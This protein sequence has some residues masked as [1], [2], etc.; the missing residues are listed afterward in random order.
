MNYLKHCLWLFAV[1][2]IVITDAS[3]GPACDPKEIRY[4]TLTTETKDGYRFDMFSPAISG[5]MPKDTSNIPFYG[6]ACSK[7]S[8]LLVSHGDE[9]L[10]INRGSAEYT[11]SSFWLAKKED[12]RTGHK[13]PSNTNVTIL[14]YTGGI[15][16]CV[17]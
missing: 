12:F 6:E 17:F 4:L 9:L 5:T 7:D 13:A 11:A 14:E 2:L 3:A 15:S 10:Y 1:L 16:C 8:Y